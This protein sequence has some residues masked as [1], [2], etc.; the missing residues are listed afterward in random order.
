MAVCTLKIFPFEN[1]TAHHLSHL[2][3][4]RNF[5]IHHTFTFLC[6]WL[7]KKCLFAM[8]FL[9]VLIFL[10]AFL[11]VDDNNVNFLIWEREVKVYSRKK[12]VNHIFLSSNFKFLLISACKSFPNAFF[13]LQFSIRFKSVWGL[14]TFKLKFR[15]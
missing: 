2:K 5:Y 15:E 13:I 8:F 4:K 14:W 9:I 10:F 6:G 11:P 1:F 12:K 7:A 3:F